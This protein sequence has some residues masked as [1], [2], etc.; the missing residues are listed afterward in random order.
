M[1]LEDDL[2]AQRHARI[3]EI[4]ALGF[5]SYGH[6]F[7]F[8]HTI[9]AVVSLYGSKT[10]EESEPPVRVRIAGRIQ[11]VRRMGKAGFAHLSQ[12]GERLQIYVRKDA[13]SEQD[14]QL[15]QLLDLGDVIGVEGYLFRTRTGELSVHAEK[16]FFLAKTLLAMPEKWHGLEDVETRYRQRYLDLIA[17]PEVRRVFVTR[18]RIVASLRRQLEERG[19][20]EVETPM[21]QPLYGGA[22]ARPF[23]T[24][25]NT[26]DIDLYLRIAPELYLKRLVVGG[27]DRVYEI[28]RNFRNEGISTHHNPEFTML[29]FYQAYT[30]Y[31]GLMDLS[32]ELLRQVAIDATGGARVEYQG[33]TLDFGAV[34]RFSMRDAVIE[35]WQGDGR[36]TSAQVNDRAWLLANS[37]EQTPGKALA[38]IFERVAEEQ[39]IQPTIIYDYPVETSPLSKNKPDEPDFVERFEIY[40]GGMEIG[41]AYT[42]LNDPQ[43]QRRRFEMQLAMLAGGDEEAHRM[44][45]DYL[46]ALSYG[47][48]P[49]GGEGIGIDRLTMLLTDSRSIRDVILFPLLRPEGEIG[50][51]ERLRALE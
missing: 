20:I 11:T 17:N 28:N 10:F 26:L 35:F 50:M 5:Q 40:A 1:S 8:S 3:R 6:R 16:L 19:F 48:P 49:T 38:S 44:D 41:N 23:T 43:E 13:V 33:T 25:H 7:D 51:A 36:P 37:H 2:F 4:E 32:C 24:H 27:L 9:P 47:M 12:E 30:D 46:R 14:Y 34:R 29:E 42:E 18:A 22:T 15:Y 39:L 31:H 45:E 21:M